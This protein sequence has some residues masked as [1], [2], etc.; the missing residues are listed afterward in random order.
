MRNFRDL[1]GI[2]TRDGRHVASGRI[3]RGE[4]PHGADDPA[5]TRII[6]HGIRV[7]CDLRGSTER[8]HRPNV[9]PPG[10][11]EVLALPILPD[12]RTN[13]G[14]AMTN[15]ATDPTGQ[16]ARDHL[17]GN[18]ELMAAGALDALPVLATRLLD[19]GDVPLMV[20]C[21]EGKDRTGFV[22]SLLLAAV[23]VDRDRMVEEYLRSA[24]NFDVDRAVRTLHASLGP[25][26]P[27]V[28]MAAVDG[29]RVDVSYLDRAFAVVDR[30]YGGVDTYLER[31]GLDAGRRDALRELLLSAG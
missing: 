11:P 5:W 12:G 29:L 20:C 2:P 27:P 13:G 19:H 14:P 7:I 8:E 24:P 4:A 3:F 22:C 30:D 23:G 1:G 28:S 18:Y 6:E 10:G 25:D 17:G 9:A 16:L 15:L 31:A 26:D 21:F